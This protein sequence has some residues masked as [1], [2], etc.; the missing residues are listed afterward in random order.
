M[1]PPGEKS[2]PQ[3][4]QGDAKKTKDCQGA[5]QFQVGLPPLAAIFATGFDL[6]DSVSA[7]GG[8]GARFTVLRPSCSC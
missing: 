4:T 7:S 6:V 5:F 3:G 1:A 2:S 8:R